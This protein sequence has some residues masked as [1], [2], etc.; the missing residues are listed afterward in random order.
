[1]DVTWGMWAEG[2]GVIQE[3]VEEEVEEVN[4]TFY[5]LFPGVVH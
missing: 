5:V 4:E 2:G 1:M 3:E